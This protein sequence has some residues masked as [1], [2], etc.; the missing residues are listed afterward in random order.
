MCALSLA[1]GLTRC[2]D[3]KSMTTLETPIAAD[4]S[5]LQNIADSVEP[6]RAQFNADR[7][8]VRMLLILSPT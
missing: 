8:K 3:P 2:G 6:L 7:G 5:G 4:H 1:A